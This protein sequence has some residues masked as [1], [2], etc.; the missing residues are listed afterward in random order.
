M[1]HCDGF[2]LPAVRRQGPVT[3]SG[4]PR[5]RPREG[6][7]PHRSDWRRAC[8]RAADARI[9]IRLHLRPQMQA[10]SLLQD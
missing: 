5:A 4:T 9:G 1:G 2:C 10:E 3:V 6:I 7:R 8:D